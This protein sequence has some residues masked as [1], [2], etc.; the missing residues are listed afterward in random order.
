MKTN[1][2][3]PAGAASDKL[4]VLIFVHGMYHGPWCWR[5]FVAFF[6]GLGYACDPVTLRGHGDQ[7]KGFRLFSARLSHFANDVV[8]AARKHERPV[9]LVGHSMG[10]LAV[11]RAAELIHPAGIILLAPASVRSFRRAMCQ[12]TCSHPFRSMAAT[13]LLYPRIAVLN[14][15]VVKE[16]FFSAEMR[17]EDVAQEWRQLQNES[18]LA[19]MQM[20]LGPRF[21]C[22]TYRKPGDTPVL[23]LGAVRDRSAS[24]DLVEQIAGD[25]GVDAEILPRVAHDMM[26]D[27]NWESVARRMQEW[28]GKLVPP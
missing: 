18:W 10:A 7:P 19:S 4:P 14:P 9:V 16:L 8:A 28:L 21:G 27:C 25:M 3:Q 5:N 11:I 20:L 1:G 24:P 13:V 15:N 23:V 26:L 6:T 22:P 17:T 12:F 2:S